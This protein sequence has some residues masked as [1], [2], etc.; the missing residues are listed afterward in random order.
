MKYVDL[1][2]FIDICAIFLNAISFLYY[3]Q[4]NYFNWGR[5][6]LVALLEVE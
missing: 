4:K 6:M 2:M 3:T 5:A 1:W